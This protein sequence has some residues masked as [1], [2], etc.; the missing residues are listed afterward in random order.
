MKQIM[1]LSINQNNNNKL[2]RRLQKRIKGAT[3][4]F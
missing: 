3:V 2:Q 1:D 4:N